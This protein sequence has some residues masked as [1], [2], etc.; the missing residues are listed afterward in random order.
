MK[1]KIK[2]ITILLILTL[3]VGISLF[4]K[5]A[6]TSLVIDAELQHMVQRLSYGAT[7]GELARIKS[8]G[9]ESYLKEQLSP[10]TIP[11]SSYLQQKLSKFKTLNLTP[12]QLFAEYGL[13][14]GRK[15]QQLSEEERKR[16][17]EK[18]RLVGE[19]A[20][21]SHLLRSIYSSKQLKEVM[22]DFWLNHFNVFIGKG[23]ETRLWLG[24]YEKEAIQPYVFG[25]F[26]D[27]LEA[28]AKHPAM[29]F[30]LD[31][32][33][34]T[35]P[36]KA[37]QRGQFR[38]LNENYARELME[39][40]TLGVDGGYTQEDV[41]TLARI[42]TGWGISPQERGK[43]YFDEKRHDF[44]DKVFLGKTIKGSGMM[45]VEQ[46]LDVLAN[47]PATARHISYKL[48]QYFLVDEPPNNL[49]E[50]MAQNYLKTGGNIRSVLETLFSSSEFFDPKY[51]DQKFKTP[52]QYIIS[53]ARATGVEQA[54]LRVI[55]GMLQQLNMGVFGCQ[56]PDG[57][58]NT[59][60]AWL[61]PDAMLRRLSFTTAIANGNLNLGEKQPVNFEE[62]MNT[63]GNQ[64]SEQ[65]KEVINNTPPKLKSAVILGSPEMMFK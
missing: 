65:T 11:E 39:L 18:L 60:K 57:Y 6:A 56:T 12:V 64:F 23:Q 43:F 51:Y 31:N 44:S 37:N 32:W 10:E 61:N 55:N 5:Q 41:T 63:L 1:L 22:I 15:A 46:T 13:T 28:T 27:L 9:I 62:L 35:A 29:L 20:I 34:N 36:E 3:I 21:Y 50:K 2:Y 45:E 24:N 8:L 48:A 58:K 54:N 30:Y 40:H 38:G 53:M 26:R 7:P 19:E 42:L 49:V 47:H 4:N 33:R 16:E 52:Y 25:N 14:R 59:Q 17:R